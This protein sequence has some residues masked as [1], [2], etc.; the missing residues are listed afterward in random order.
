MAY[1]T[2]ADLREQIKE[3]DLIQLTDD[4]SVLSSSIL[5]G[6]ISA[7]A[8]TIILTDASGFPESGRIE[9]DLEQIDYTGKIGNQLI[10]CLRG[11]NKTTP[12]AHCTGAAVIE[13]NTIIMSVVERAIADADA[14]IDS[15]CAARY[16][17]LPFALVPIMVRKISVDIAI[18][19]LYARR[20]GAPDDRR[21]RYQ[22][23][24]RFL[25]NVANGI[26]YL[27]ADAPDTNDDPGPRASGSE[28]DRI[29]TMGRIS[30]SS[31]GTLDRY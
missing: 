8:T 10:Y 1:C 3:D 14:E 29:F 16:A 18:Y 24:V 28:I 25:E 6:D 4:R 11:V 15:Y 12:A 17:N 5:N 7:A 31:S 23:V 30:D 22:S 2:L 20:K 13:L 19:N 9:I 27:G 26:A 21:D